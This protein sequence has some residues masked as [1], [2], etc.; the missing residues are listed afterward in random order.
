MR[1]RIQIEDK[2]KRKYSKSGNISIFPIVEGICMRHLK[3]G[4]ELKRSEPVESQ[5]S[6]QRCSRMCAQHAS[7]TFWDIFRTWWRRVRNTLHACTWLAPAL[8]S[9]SFPIYNAQSVKYFVSYR[10]VAC[11]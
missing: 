4:D 3:Y 9:V 11:G 7:C 6:E 2:S 5:N 8:R 1:N 10:A